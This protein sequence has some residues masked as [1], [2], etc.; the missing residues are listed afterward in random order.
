MTETAKKYLSTLFVSRASF[1]KRLRVP[2]VLGLF[3][4]LTYAA[5]GALAQEEGEYFDAAGVRLHYTD[6]GSGEPIILLHGFGL[7]QDFSWRNSGTLDALAQRYRVIALD[8]RGHGLSDK[9]QQPDAYGIEMARDVIRLMDHLGLERAHIAG[10]SMGAIVTM[11]VM[12]DYPERVITAM[13]CSMGWARPFG[14]NMAALVATA[15]TL[16]AG[17]GVG[18]LVARLYPG[19]EPGYLVSTAADT[20]INYLND[21]QALAS[22]A[23]ALTE[24]AVYEEELRAV[25]VPVLTVVGSDDPLAEDVEPMH[26]LIPNHQIVVLDGADHFRVAAWPGFLEMM[27]GFID[28]H[29]ESTLPQPI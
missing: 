9:P 12:V 16:D 19:H 18:P 6:Q 23:R 5:Q 26:G 20:L 17:E 8:Q 2:M 10:T 1:F 22:V 14:P 11:R 24:L 25:K 4:A 7:N 29:S 21:E 27:T 15:H 13:P 3:A 28:K